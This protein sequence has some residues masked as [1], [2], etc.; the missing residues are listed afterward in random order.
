MTA[1]F[2]LSPVS[3]HARL[4]HAVTYMHGKLY[5]YES[6]EPVWS[7]GF[8][9]LHGKTVNN[10]SIAMIVDRVSFPYAANNHG[11]HWKMRADDIVLLLLAANQK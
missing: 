8:E 4:Y 1:I 5:L 2:K 7:H 9:Y 10:I 6:A 11:V 3:L